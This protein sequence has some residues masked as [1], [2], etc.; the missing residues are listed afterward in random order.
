M[1]KKVLIAAVVLA[2]LGGGSA[3][4]AS[5]WVI[6]STRQIKPSVLRHLHGARG[7]QGPRGFQG[8]QGLP[9]SSGIARVQWVNSSSVPYCASSGGACSVAS[10]TAT[11]PPGSVAVGGAA[12]ASSIETSISTYVGGNIYEAVSDNASPFTGDLTAT[13]VCASGPGINAA[14]DARAASDPAGALVAK[15]RGER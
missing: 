13:A 6:T 11:C 10:A 7:Q 14:K 2:V 8:A 15:L 9:G 1:F 3:F 12:N 4:A 5:R